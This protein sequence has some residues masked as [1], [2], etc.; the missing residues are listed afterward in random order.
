MRDPVELL[1]HAASDARVPAVPSAVLVR[2]GRARRRRLAASLG[3]ISGVAALV[4][5]AAV[6][7]PSAAPPPRPADP[8][9]NVT[10]AAQQAA[11]RAADPGIPTL[12]SVRTDLSR[13][14]PPRLSARPA[15][16]IGLGIDPKAG[17]SPAATPIF[18]Q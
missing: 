16:A 15:A 4:A 17:A 2:A 10:I 5:F 9:P 1:S 3:S 7:R 14:D 11:Q 18:L 8:P 6:L 13:L 12:G